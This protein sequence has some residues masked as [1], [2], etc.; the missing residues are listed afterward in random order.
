M[1]R[2]TLKILGFSKSHKDPCLQGL[3]R[4]V[5]KPVSFILTK[6]CS[7]P[8]AEELPLKAPTAHY[9]LSELSTIGWFSC[10]RFLWGWGLWRR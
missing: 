10:Y 9:F 1:N 3:R 2:E 4:V 7:P 5:S 6:C 8:A